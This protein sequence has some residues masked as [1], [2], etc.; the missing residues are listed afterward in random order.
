MR[1]K[2]LYDRDLGLVHA[3]TDRM[4]AGLMLFQWLAIVL[5]A[6]YI[7]PLTWE[8]AQSSIHI[9]VWAAILLGGAIASAPIYFALTQPGAVITRQ[10]IAVAQMLMSGLLI[11]V[12]GGRIETHFHVFGSLAF[13]AFYRDWRV[14]VTASV[15]TAADHLIRGTYFPASI[16]GVETVNNWRWLEHTGWVVFEDIFLV[17]ACVRGTA[18]MK[19][20]GMRQAQLEETNE[21]LVATATMLRDSEERVR[22]VVSTSMDAVILVDSD[23]FVADWN[24]QAE[25]I[26]GYSAGEAFG[27]RIVDLVVPP[28]LRQESIDRLA[29]VQSATVDSPVS[30]RSR[31]FSCRK[32]GTEF[33]SEI[34]ITTIFI[35]NRLM[36][37]AF[38]RDMSNVYE[39]EAAR[40]T[41]LERIEQAR[42]QALQLTRAKSAFLANMSHEI[43]TP[44]NGIL[45][46]TNLLLGTDLDQE[47]RDFTQ[48]VQTS[49]HS[50]L[51]VI[52]DILDFSKIEA[53]KLKISEAEFSVR[54]V[55]MEVLDLLAHR[56]QDKDIALAYYIAPE[57][58]DR[59]LGDPLRIQQILT[60]L[61]GNAIKFTDSG[62]VVVESRVIHDSEK[63][64]L[65]R[66]I[67]RDTGIGIPQSRHASIF[68]SFTQ[69]DGS[70]TRKYGGSGLGLTICKQLVELMEGKIGVESEEGTGSNFWFELTL[71]KCLSQPECKSIAKM[72]SGRKPK[73]LVAD[74]NS[75]R[76]RGIQD[77]LRYWNCIVEGCATLDELTAKVNALGSD[78]SYDVI[79]LDSDLATTASPAEG[80]ARDALAHLSA[81]IILTASV[82]ATASLRQTFGSLVAAI[83]TK[84][85]RQS[86]L[87]DSIMN[88]LNADASAVRPQVLSAG[89][90]AEADSTHFALNILLAEDNLVNIKVATH[91]L[92]RWGCDVTSAETGAEAIKMLQTCRFDLV[93]MDVQMPEM[94][95]IDATA[96]IRKMQVE[97]QISGTIPIIA[98]TAH[99]MEGDRERCIAAGMDDY[100]SKPVEPTALADA[101]RRCLD[102][103]AT[104][105]PKREETVVSSNFEVLRLSRLAAMVGDD[106]EFEAEVVSDFL[107]GATKHV[108]EICEAFESG[109]DEKLRLAAHALKGSCRTLGAEALGEVCQELEK[110][111]AGGHLAECSFLIAQAKAQH[112]SLEAA[113]RRTLDSLSIRAVATGS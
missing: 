11:H 84:P 20:I 101:I 71:A 70:T 3:R 50:L 29:S 76:C 36:L 32:D 53:G 65:V 2:E 74:A 83:L 89:S 44:L 77:H 62:E 10:V 47:Q 33:P 54:D 18:E 43:R 107:R 13:L 57:Y 82:G 80:S 90:S 1:A 60:N 55:I 93:L 91:I 97:G 19:D 92:E 39:A 106:P 105:A 88:V 100:V 52:N 69:A 46:M 14:L 31:T 73:L 108:G 22:L 58:P 87:F 103:P 99:A 78:E 21:R 98:M 6:I 95:G 112:I 4:F 27:H 34:S 49:G 48:T 23:G 59:L 9:H 85:I 86:Y 64:V 110:Q 104:G 35:D 45:G 72:E 7:S 26:T 66:F 25:T 79:I 12:T 42:D 37:S 96:R 113:M 17:Y 102:M 5:A 61:I 51:E 63:Q 30:S 81:P 16:Y 111:A 8:G 41:Y 56:A 15:V 40:Q 24:P 94:D 67:V 28:R 75:T 38:L 109:N 68:E